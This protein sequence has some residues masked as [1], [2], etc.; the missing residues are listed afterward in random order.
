MNKRIFRALVVLLLASFAVQCVLYPRL[1]QTVPVHWNMQGQVDSYGGKQMQLFFAL[2]PVLVV[3]GMQALPYAD[4]KRENYKKYRRAYGIVAAAISVALAGFSWITMLAGLGVQLPVGTLVLCFI[5]AMFV[6]MGNYMPQFRLN[7]FCGIRTPWTIASDTV[8]R[9]T[10]RL[11]GIL[12]VLAG[13]ALIA[14]GF[15]PGPVSL[16]ATIAVVS[17]A[18]LAPCVYSFVIYKKTTNREEKHAEN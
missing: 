8:W 13:L 17:L 10:H 14:F 11:G 15:M 12:F 4:P 9:K 1:P 2:L 3:V 18:G 16:W 6:V 5:G 7:F